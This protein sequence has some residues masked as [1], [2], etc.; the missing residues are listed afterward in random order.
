M[1]QAD[2]VRKL[3]D[4]RY[5]EAY[6]DL[7]L[8][9][10]REKYETNTKILNEVLAASSPPTPYW[11]DLACGQAFQFAAVTRA[12]WKLGVDLSESQLRYARHWN[13]DASFLVCDMRKLPCLTSSFDLVTCF[14]GAYCYLDDAAAIARFVARTIDYVRPGGAWYFEILPPDSLATFNASE[15]AH[16]TGFRVTPRRPDY[17]K[18]SYDDVAGS[19]SMTSPR[20]DEF[21]RVLTPTF[22]NIEVVRQDFMTHVLATGRVTH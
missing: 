4:A 10:W 2:A 19:H 20:L 14:W 15:F 6:P 22:E 8:L 7:Y 9:P 5:A 3:Y 16:A 21:T 17:T 12:C 11:L 13:P 18:W 1:T